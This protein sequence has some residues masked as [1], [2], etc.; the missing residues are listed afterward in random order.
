MSLSSFGVLNSLCSF[1][2]KRGQPETELVGS[3][4]ILVSIVSA[5]KGERATAQSAVSGQQGLRIQS[6]SAP[7][8]SFQLQRQW[9][10]QGSSCPHWHLCPVKLGVFSFVGWSGHGS[11]CP[12]SHLCPRNW[13]R[14][15]LVWKPFQ[16]P[17]GFFASSAFFFASA[18]LSAPSSFLSSPSALS[19]FFSSSAFFFSSNISCF[20]QLFHPFPAGLPTGQGSPALISASPAV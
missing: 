18:F 12:H 11:S 7:S 1:A 5:S 16:L 3:R 9:S 15:S 4:E 2:I 17:F 10:G 8:H 14:C 13:V 20:V 19:F 6:R